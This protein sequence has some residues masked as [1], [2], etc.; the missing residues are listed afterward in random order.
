MTIVG[1]IL[2]VVSIRTIAVWNKNLFVVVPLVI[3]SLGQWGI[4]LHGITTVSATYV[5]ETNSCN[6]AQ[7]EGLFLN[8]VY[9]WSES[10]SPRIALLSDSLTI[11]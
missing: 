4:L 1:A 9:L 11:L 7:V 6:V 3:I 5:P 8:L 2:I 10:N